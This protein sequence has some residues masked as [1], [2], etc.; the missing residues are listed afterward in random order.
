[1]KIRRDTSRASTEKKLKFTN[2]SKRQFVEDIFKI[3]ELLSE[4]WKG[5]TG[6]KKQFIRGEIKPRMVAHAFTPSTQDA[7]AGGSL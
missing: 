4:I 7:E 2:K 3:P 6:R 1:M 5:S